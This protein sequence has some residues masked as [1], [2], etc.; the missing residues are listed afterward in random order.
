MDILSVV[1][2]FGAP[3]PE[4]LTRTFDIRLRATSTF[5]G[6]L[7]VGALLLVFGP[8][9]TERVIRTIEDQPGPSFLYGVVVFVALIVVTIV[10]VLTIVGILVAI[11]LLIVVGLLY[12][13]GSA[14]VFVYVGQRLLE[15]LD[16]DTSRW[17]HLLAGSLV[18]GVL[19]GVPLVGGLLNFVVNAVG[20]GAMVYRWQN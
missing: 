3:D 4:T 1:L 17:G 7:V 20:I 8:D 11:P 19:A 12:L 6:T 2:Q 5:L 18:A 13:V 14:I 10:L 9:F 16:V 15:A